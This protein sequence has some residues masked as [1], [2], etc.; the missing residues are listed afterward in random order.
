VTSQIDL[1]SIDDKS[2][3]VLF[4]KHSSQLNLKESLVRNMI[5]LIRNGLRKVSNNIDIYV[6][7]QYAPSS[8]MVVGQI[9]EAV[10]DFSTA[11]N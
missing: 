5:V 7:L 3:V 6:Q 1:E 11:N 8:L 4:V 10:N 9:N 2:R